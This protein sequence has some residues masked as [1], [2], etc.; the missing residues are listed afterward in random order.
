MGLR[1]NQRKA[2]RA[3]N[4]RPPSLIAIRPLTPT[5]ANRT[6][7]CWRSRDRIRARL[8]GAPLG[9]ASDLVERAGGAGVNRKLEPRRHE[10]GA[11]RAQ[12]ALSAAGGRVV[13]AVTT[14]GSQ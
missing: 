14:V 7:A 1:R 3:A 12:S 9:T 4:V 6:W 13:R 5:S 11:L 8:A 10:G 2:R